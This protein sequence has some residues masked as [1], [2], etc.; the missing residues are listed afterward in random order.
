SRTH[1]IRL[2]PHYHLEKAEVIVSFNA[3]FLGTWISPV[4]FTSAY[5]ASRRLEGPAPRLSY[6]VH[7]ESLLSLTGTKADRRLCIA[8]GEMGAT[9]NH[10]ATRLANKVG[11]AFQEGS[12]E[13]PPISGKFLDHLA[14]FL[15]RNRQRSLILCGS[16]DLDLQLLCNFLNQVLGNYGTTV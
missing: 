12:A 10:L 16:E 14:D 4:E 9:M 1:G 8:P 2:L 13:E 3:D 15:L 7:F 6:H 5:Q 11:V